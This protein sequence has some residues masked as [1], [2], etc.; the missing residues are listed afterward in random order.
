MRVGIGSLH[1]SSLWSNIMALDSSAC[2]IASS[3]LMIEV[4]FEYKE[5]KAII[6]SKVTKICR[7]VERH[8]S[9]NIGLNDPRVFT[10]SSKGRSTITDY[11]LLQRWMSSWKTF[12]NVDS[13][14]QLKNMDRITVCQV[15]AV[16][17]SDKVCICNVATRA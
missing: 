16:S 6:Q 15:S 13:S 8:L 17:S 7:Q 10:L 3:S 12:V 2:S 11:Y 1:T 5:Y 14:E 9:D 4:L